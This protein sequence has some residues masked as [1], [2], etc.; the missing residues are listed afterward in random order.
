MEKPGVSRSDIENILRASSEYRVIEE[1]YNNL[2]DR[3]AGFSGILKTHIDKLR[4]SGV[5]FEYENELDALL[6]G[7]G[8][9]ASVVNGVVNLVNFKDRVV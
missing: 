5:R 4:G 2:R 7:E 6:R 8:M 9:S 3:F 1:K